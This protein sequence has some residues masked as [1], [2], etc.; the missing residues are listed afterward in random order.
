MLKMAHP[1]HAVPPA[2][3]E[4]EDVPAWGRAG[5]NSKFKIEN[6]KLTCGWVGGKFEIRNSKFKRDGRAENSKFE[7]RNSLREA[8]VKIP[9]S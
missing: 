8:R 9:H 7:I 6:S 3:N 4:R 2:L 1:P 5:G